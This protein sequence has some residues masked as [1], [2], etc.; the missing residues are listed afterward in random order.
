MRKTFL[1]SS[2]V[3]MMLGVEVHATAATVP[4]PSLWALLAGGVAA[5][6]IIKRLKGG[7]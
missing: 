4:E 7:D 2:V 1:I 5:G 6:V 3:S